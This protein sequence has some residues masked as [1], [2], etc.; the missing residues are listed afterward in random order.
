MQCTTVDTYIESNSTLLST[1]KPIARK[2]HKCSECRRTISKGT[3]YLKE[4]VVYD[5]I[6]TYKLCPTCE[7]IRSTFFQ[8]WTYTHLMDDLYNH[9]SDCETISEDVILK[10]IPEAQTLVLKMMEDK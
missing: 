7:S 1:S 8:S 6:A 4:T 9:V 10:L 2:D 3:P 5:G